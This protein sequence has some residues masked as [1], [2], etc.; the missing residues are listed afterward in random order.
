MTKT[1]PICHRLKA[2]AAL[3]LIAA[4]PRAPARTSKPVKM[5]V[6][7][8]AGGTMDVV[9]RILA[10]AISSEIGQPV[11]VDNKPGAGGAI[12]VQALNSAPADGQTIMVTASNILTEI[13]LVMKTSFDPIT[14]V[15]PVTLVARASMVLV[16]AQAVPA[17]DL[18]AL[19]AYLKT[20]KGGKASFASYSAGTS[21]HY[22]GMMFAK[23]AGLDLQH[24][25]FAGSPPALQ[26]LMGGQIDI[27]FDG[28]VTSMPQ[29]KG[30]K[31]KAYGVASK[32][33]SVH[34]PDVPTLAEQGYAEIDF[35]NWLGTVVSAKLPDDI[36]SRINIAT[37]KAA[38]SPAVRDRLVS[39]GFEPTVSV[40]PAELAQMVKTDHER[41]AVIV[42][43]FDIRLDR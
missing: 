39:V 34:L 17:G 7:A 3:L 37:V 19:T 10:E 25:P 14:D 43:A 18:K 5:I 26:Q 21:S 30:G 20:N 40:S 31:L 27:M 42:K 33:R 12:A 13:P 2:V 22:A 6:P 32:T 8:P 41:N 36:V 11:I 1:L 35:S 28:I 16:A 24:V 29:I 38:M 4:A 15:K 23:K 9:A